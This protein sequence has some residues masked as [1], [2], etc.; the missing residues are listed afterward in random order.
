MVRKVLYPAVFVL[1]ALMVSTAY[2]SWSF[3]SVYTFTT[4]VD[5]VDGGIR[6]NDGNYVDDGSLVQYIIALDDHPIVDPLEYFG[7][8]ETGNNLVDTPLELAEVTT[9]LNNGADPADISGGYNVLATDGTVNFAGEFETVDGKL[10]LHGITNWSAGE[11]PLYSS[12]PPSISQGLGLDPLAIRAWNLSK[13]EMAD[14]CTVGGVEAWYMTSRE[15]GMSSGTYAPPD[16]AMVVG[17]GYVPDGID[18]DVFGWGGMDAYVGVEVYM[19]LKTQN[20]TDVFLAECPIPEPGTMLLIG[21]S[22]L[23]LL[24]RR[25]K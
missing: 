2:G 3:K 20:R 22:A 16:M 8:L 21:S 18:P 14:F 15:R 19:A 11:D 24:L 4:E 1:V 9:W 23:L 13:E 25:K 6:D 12:S 17:L 10:S 7:S 5:A